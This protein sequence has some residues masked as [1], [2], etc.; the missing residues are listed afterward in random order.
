MKIK[1]SLF[2][3]W[4]TFKKDKLF[5]MININFTLNQTGFWLSVGLVGVNIEI[6]FTK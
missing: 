5:T 3:D 4:K 6:D 1:P 2:I